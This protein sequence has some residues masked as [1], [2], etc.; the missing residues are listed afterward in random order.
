MSDASGLGTT[1]ALNTKIRETENKIPET[2][3]LVATAVRN[4]KIEQLE[5]KNPGISSLIKK[6]KM[7]LK[8]HKSSENISLHL[9]ITNLLL[10]YLMHG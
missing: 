1:A 9:I 6:K 5:N 3:G 2:S 7:P 4:T 8:Y 10:T